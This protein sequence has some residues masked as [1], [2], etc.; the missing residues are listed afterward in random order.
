MPRRLVS[1]VV[2]MGGSVLHTSAGLGTSKFAPFRFFCRPEASV[3]EL[4]PAQ[5]PEPAA[6]HA[7]SAAAR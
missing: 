1:G 6:A 2:R 7:T 3:L 4:H 5:V